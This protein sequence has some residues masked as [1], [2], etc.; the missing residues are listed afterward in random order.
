M[1]IA[2][3]TADF[4]VPVLGTKGAS[5]H[6]RGLVEALR[7]EG[8]DL[9]VLAANIGEDSEPSFPLRQVP[10]GSTL[11]ELYDAL[12]NESISDLFRQACFEVVPEVS[13]RRLALYEA[14][15]L[16]AYV[17][18]SFRKR[19]HQTE[20]LGWAKGQIASAWERLDHAAA[21]GRLV[22]S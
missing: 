19:S 7:S 11:R 14:L 15:D 10:F 22:S 20:W 2:Y 13:S 16:S 21:D 6:V 3:P 12:Q 17:L 1:R 4:G 5:A 8:R 9:F 18:R